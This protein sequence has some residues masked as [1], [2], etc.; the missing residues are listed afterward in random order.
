MN[1]KDD[2]YTYWAVKKDKYWEIIINSINNLSEGNSTAVIYAKNDNK[3]EEIGQYKFYINKYRYTPE[4]Y[5]QNNS[6]WSNIK[7][8]SY[9]MHQ[10]GC[11]P[12]SLA[13]AFSGILDYSV[14][15]MDVA[16]Y[17]YNETFE[18]NKP[19]AGGSGLGIEYASNH[20]NVSYQKINSLLEV[21]NALKK[22]MIVTAAVGP[23]FFTTPGHTHQIILF[24]NNYGY[25]SVY[26]PYDS[27]KNGIYSINEIWN[28]Q[29]HDPYDLRGGYVFYS[30]Y[31]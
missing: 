8:G 1:G 28:Q 4:Y 9:T 22:G 7:W 27:G 31:Q 29:S 3:S 16:S 15:P 10:S 24:G 23:G 26:D 5:S 12:T 6:N 20:W 18:F 17:L 13:M 14:S 19:I 25:T 11:L 21:E 30:L 2:L